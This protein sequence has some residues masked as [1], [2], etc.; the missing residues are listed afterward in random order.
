[1]N[2]LTLSLKEQLDEID[3][4]LIEVNFTNYYISRKNVLLSQW[5]KGEVIDKKLQ[6]TP[7]YC[8]FSNGKINYTK[9][10][11]D[12]GR[13][14]RTLK[15]WHRDYNKYPWEIWER[16]AEEKAKA[17]T[18]GA[19]G[20]GQQKYIEPPP[21]PEGTYEI[22]YADPPWQ[23]SDE[24]IKE[25]GAAEHHYRTMA[26]EELCEMELPVIADNAVLFLWTTAPI[27][28]DAFKIIRAWG[29]EYKT[30]FVW[31]KVKHNY[32]HYNSVRHEL[33]LICTRGSYLPQDKKL[34]DSVQTI[35]RTAEHSEKPEGFRA[36]ID[37]L[38]PEGNRI[39]L[40]A[41]KEVEGWE[42]WGNEYI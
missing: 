7:L 24:L 16:H 31:D 18:I 10:Q 20:A 32:G 2:E 9:M 11:K 21:I 22:I 33:L 26:I 29:F 1:M 8:R 30:Q 36:I 3:K 38:Y 25:Y 5:K 6:S 15:G 4:Q 40:F 27:A 34:F 42:T 13:N 41:R 23:Y 35:E 19:L 28:D 17:W 37:T 12:T 39:E 14:Y